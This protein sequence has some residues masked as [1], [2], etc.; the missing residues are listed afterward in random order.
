LVGNRGRTQQQLAGIRRKGDLK[1]RA[2]T[3]YIALFIVM[4]TYAG[5]STVLFRLADVPFDSDEAQHALDG[6]QIAADIHHGDAR[7]FLDHFYFTGWYPPLLPT[8]LGLF[9]TFLKPS[10][11]SARYAILLLAIVYL[12]LMYRVSGKLAKNPV[13]GLI[14]MSLAATSPLLWIHGVLCME[15]ML[16]MIGLLLTILAYVQA[17]DGKAHPAWVGLGMAATLL[18]RLSIGIY[19]AGA[20]ALMLGFDWLKNGRVRFANTGRMIAPFLVICAIWWGHP[21]KIETLIDY[22]RASPPAYES[23]GWHQIG[24]YW[25]AIATSATASPLIGIVVLASVVSAIL[26]WREKAWSLPLA[27]LATTWM[28]LLFKRQLNLRFFVGGLS[29]AFLITGQSVTSFH[30][31]LSAHR[32]KWLSL[33]YRVL[34]LVVSAGTVPFLLAR[35]ASFPLLIEVAYE[36]DPATT[37]LFAWVVG[38]VDDETPIFFVN[39]WDPIS[40]SGLN[41]YLGMMTWPRWRFPQATDVLLVDPGKQPQLVEQFHAALSSAPKSY[42]VHLSNTPV[43]NAG[44]WWAYQPALQSCWPGDWQAATSFWASSWDGNLESEI[45]R[46]PFRYAYG[47]SRLAARGN[48]RY[49]LLIETKIAECQHF[50]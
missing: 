5:L 44:A 32:E 49:P 31:W 50:G 3:K 25:S 11:W 14:T 30:S 27:I 28:V 40:T 2:Y 6:L 42:V 23:L 10:Y 26:H 1:Q 20:I 37:S 29:S 35:I 34:V 38:N 9:F 36:T 16:A 17:A 45:M 47:A 39:G 33:S 13:S 22:I 41:F 43:P 8:Y 48:Y 15:E 4:V 24:Y 46:R 12:A 18:A 19:L 21:A 7:S